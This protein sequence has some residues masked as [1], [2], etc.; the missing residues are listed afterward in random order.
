[1][2][3]W[4]VKLGLAAVMLSGP[5]V[6]GAAP[7]G[8]VVPALRAAAAWSAAPTAVRWECGPYRCVYR[9]PLGPYVG[10]R[11]PYRGFQSPYAGPRG[12]NYGPRPGLYDRPRAPFYGPRRW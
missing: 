4:F 2:R 9:P 5:S 1:M 12:F 6:S 11:G 7:V 8:N 10:S 3:K